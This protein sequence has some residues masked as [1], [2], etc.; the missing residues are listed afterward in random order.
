MFDDNNEDTVAE[1]NP[2]GARQR[3]VPGR[4]FKAVESAINELDPAQII[5]ERF[6]LT[7]R[8]SKLPP[9]IPRISRMNVTLTAH[10]PPPPI[11]MVPRPTSRVA[12]LLTR[13]ALPIGGTIVAA[14][15]SLYLTLPARTRYLSAQI[16]PA[17]VDH[18][19]PSESFQLTATDDQ[20]PGEPADK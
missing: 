12:R 1:P 11:V 6:I 15:L 19:T 9:P 10:L 3:V 14:L 13:F 17:T 18:E 7:Q 16:T 5:D 8:V 2:F 4:R 20:P